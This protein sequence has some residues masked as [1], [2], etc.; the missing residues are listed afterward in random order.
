ML[1]SR[2]TISPVAGEPSQGRDSQSNLSEG[3]SREEN[4]KPTK[5][6]KRESKSATGGLEEWDIYVKWTASITD[7]DSDENGK[8]AGGG[9]PPTHTIEQGV[10]AVH[11]ERERGVA[12]VKD[13]SSSLVIGTSLGQ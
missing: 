11:R 7:E 12:D 4:G 6:Q 8:P 2:G 13:A 1:A 9:G 10:L 5:K 3:P